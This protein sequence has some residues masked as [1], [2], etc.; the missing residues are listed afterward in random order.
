MFVINYS[1]Y[2]E[3]VSLVWVWGLIKGVPI[4]DAIQG[5]GF[6]EHEWNE[7]ALRTMHI[8]KTWANYRWRSC[9]NNI[10][11]WHISRCLIV[12]GPGVRA[13]GYGVMIWGLGMAE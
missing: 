1:T 6:M 7:G 9:R 12:W 8:G 2:A 5:H 4:K 10:K 13:Q 11:A 3:W